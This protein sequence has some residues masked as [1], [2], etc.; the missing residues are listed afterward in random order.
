MADV[1]ADRSATRI[2]CRGESASDHGFIPL[3]SCPVVT[4]ATCSPETN[5][6]LRIVPTPLTA[7]TI[8]MLMP[9]AIKAYSMDVAPD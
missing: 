6:L 8:T 7:A 5:V 3:R 9:I 4:S 2:E 1:C